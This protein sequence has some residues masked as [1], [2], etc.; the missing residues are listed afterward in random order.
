[1]RHDALEQ[2][3]MEAARSHPPTAQVPYAFEQRILARIKELR[4]SD[5]MAVWG[6]LFWRAAFSSLL[7]TLLASA[8]A[9]SNPPLSTPGALADDFESIVYSGLNEITYNR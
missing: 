8:W 4:R 1:M 5:P 3:L 7:I 9:A 6:R 2:K